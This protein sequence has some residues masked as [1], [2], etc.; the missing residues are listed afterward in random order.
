MFATIIEQSTIYRRTVYRCWKEGV[1][2]RNTKSIEIKYMGGECVREGVLN[3][4]SMHTKA[5]W[6]TR[7]SLFQINKPRPAD[8]HIVNCLYDLFFLLNA[9]AYYYYYCYYSAGNAPYVTNS[10]AMNSRGG[11]SFVVV[12]QPSTSHHIQV[13]NFLKRVH[14]VGAKRDLTLSHVITPQT[15]LPV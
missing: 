5:Q 15:Q 13:D 12:T 3:M 6:P 8:S 14:R 10:E 1:N 4:Y 11:W 2:G 7:K 9:P